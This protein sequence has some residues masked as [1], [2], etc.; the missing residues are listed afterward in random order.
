M[1]PYTEE[2]IAAKENKK[3]EKHTSQDDEDWG[4]K[5][6]AAAVMTDAYY[7]YTLKGLFFTFPI[8]LFVCVYFIWSDHC[9]PVSCHF[10]LYCN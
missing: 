1:F 2:G 4:N 7:Q 3:F 6:A 10:M 5:H 9:C 8:Y